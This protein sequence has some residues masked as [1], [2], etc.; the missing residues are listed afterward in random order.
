MTK[1]QIAELRR[2]A[3][4]LDDWLRIGD[5]R[6]PPMETIRTISLLSQKAAD[7]LETT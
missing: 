7:T 6:D 2:C 3:E 5:M 1:D 4:E